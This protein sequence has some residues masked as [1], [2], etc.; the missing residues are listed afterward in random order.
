VPNLSDEVFPAHLAYL[1]SYFRVRAANPLFPVSIVG[2]AAAAW[3]GW[4][5]A[6]AASGG[7]AVA[8]TLATALVVLAIVEHLFLVLPLRDGAMWRWA[9]NTPVAAAPAAVE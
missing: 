8:L 9:S 5:L 6:N 1:K 3:V 2:G 7:T 4:S